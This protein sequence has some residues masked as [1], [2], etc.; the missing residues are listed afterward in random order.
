MKKL[1]VVPTDFSPTSTN[2]TNYAADMALAMGADILLLH[3]YQVPVAVT[4][5]PL[6]LVSV[7][8]LRYEAEKKLDKLKTDLEHITSGK[9]DINT[10]ARLGDVVDELEE[11]CNTEH[12]FA[13]VMG[14]TGHS[15]LETTLFGST[16][17]RTIRHLTTPVICIPKGKEYGMG[18]K[19]IG[20]ACDLKQVEDTTPFPAIIDFV[21]EFNAELHVLNIESKNTQ[22]LPD[23]AEQTAILGT[24]INELDPQFH[25]IAHDDIEDGINEFAETHNLDLLIAIP[26]KH[27][28]LEGLFK[29]SSTKQLIKES[30]IPVMCVHE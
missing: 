20:L 13:V 7:D 24:A 17:L 25:F 26:R 3:V 12:P 16:T 19:K 27:K 8:E 5:V 6:V 11:V 18:I 15:G 10:R 1:L 28:L 14:T 4:D 22:P 30:H 21:K 23:Q 9:L 2:A 29:T